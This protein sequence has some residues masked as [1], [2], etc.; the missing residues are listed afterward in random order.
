VAK[1]L[2][3]LGVPADAMTVRWYGETRPRVPTPDDVPEPQN[4]RVEITLG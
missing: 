2:R 4:R 3:E 1:V